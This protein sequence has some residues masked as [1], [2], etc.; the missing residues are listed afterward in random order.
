MSPSESLSDIGVEVQIDDALVESVP[1]D[2]LIHAARASLHQQGI[3][4][5]A[6]LTVVITGDATVRRLNRT[7]R[8]IDA[9]TDVLAFG[10]EGADGFVIPSLAIRYLGDVII[11]LPRAEA[12][13]RDAGHS[14][15]A[16][17]LL[18]TVHGVLHL[19]GH[20]HAEP[21]EKAA[22]WSAQREILRELEKSNLA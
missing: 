7:Y 18:L 13:A 22:M 2:L 9:P 11:S 20:N 14:V 1:G 3:E 15:I 8:G 16:E 5:P 21:D 4:G 12:Q 17:L 10:S 19:L 6:E